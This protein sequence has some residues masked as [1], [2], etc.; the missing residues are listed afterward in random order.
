MMSNQ[1]KGIR[2]PTNFTVVRKFQ[3]Q[4]RVTIPS[5]LAEMLELDDKSVCKWTTTGKVLV[6]QKDKRSYAQFVENLEKRK[7]LIEAVKS[8]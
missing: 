4:F 6:L 7:E 8:E 5:G 1:G 2:L 3:G